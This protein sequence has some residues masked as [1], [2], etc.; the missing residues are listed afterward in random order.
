M[1]ISVGVSLHKLKI[2][3]SAPSAWVWLNGVA[4]MTLVFWV[5]DW[6]M[7][8]AGWFV[9]PECGGKGWWLD[10]H[11]L[12]YALLYA[13]VP[14]ISGLLFVGCLTIIAVSTL[15]KRYFALRLQ[16]VYVLLVF[17]LGSGLLVNAVFKDHWGRPRPS[18]VVELGGAQAYAPPLQYVA[19]SEG[20]SF[21]SGHSSVG[22]GFIAFWF[23]WRRRHPQR[24]KRALWGSLAFGSL[25]G[26]A[27][28]AAGGHFLSDV[29]W[30]CVMMIFAAWVLYYPLLNMPQRERRQ[31]IT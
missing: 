16:A 19:N 3:R 9:Q 28:M 25:I 4:A 20:R 11:A 10:C 8:L 29:L 18:Q 27:R 22:F 12:L 5:T 21:P 13:S 24:A 15:R 1:S 2:W 7:R 31:G 17:V 14:Y 23:L 26:L 30:S 6:D